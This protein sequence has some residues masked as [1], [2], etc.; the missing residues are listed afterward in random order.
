M[1]NR[2]FNGVQ[3]NQGATIA[4]KAGADI[5][6][7]RNR[8]MAY[9]EDGNVVP[10]SGGTKPIVGVAMVEAGWNDIS[11][12]HSGKVLK[13]EDV[14][15]QVK[16]I[17][18]ILSGGEIAKGAEVTAG[19]AGLAAAAAAGDYVIGLALDAAQKDEYCRIQIMKYQKN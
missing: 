4:E 19:E 8:A 3:I 1:A 5:E 18:Y 17:G 12:A 13:G 7:C 9:D 6:D 10:A 2:N 14:D 15:I 16:D 11:G